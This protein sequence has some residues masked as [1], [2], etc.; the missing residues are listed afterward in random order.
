MGD[1]DPG[2][3]QASRVIRIE[4]HAVSCDQ[5]RSQDP[6][7]IE[8]GHRA[9]LAGPPARLRSA[10]GEQVGERSGSGCEQLRLV[11][12][13]GQMR[14]PGTIREVRVADERV[15]EVRSDGV[16]RV[17]R[18]PDL[19]AC[20]AVVIQGDHPLGQI[21]RCVP[22]SVAG[23]SAECLEV[24]D[25]TK[26]RL[27]QGAGRRRRWDRCRRRSSSRVE[28]SAARRPPPPRG[29]RQCPSAGSSASRDPSQPE[30]PP[31]PTSPPVRL[32]SRWQCASTNPGSRIASPRSRSGRCGQSRDIWSAVPTPRSG[33]ASTAT[34]PSAIGGPAI[35]M[36]W[37]ARRRARGS[38]ERLGVVALSDRRARSARSLPVIESLNSRTPDPR[39]RATSGS[40]LAPKITS[41]MTSTMSSCG[42]P[43]CPK[44]LG[45]SRS[46]DASPT[47]VAWA[48]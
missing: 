45:P 12:R 43:I 29:G 13:F 19:N 28:G 1:A 32:H 44:A 39:L 47:R 22:G 15:P 18:D 10:R 25:A 2:R 17:G 14:G 34:D 40:R 26:A 6:G 5:T 20:A 27:A 21:A 36:T 42:Q 23:V 48:S 30:N 46:G 41:T 11:R 37:A 35:G 38:L 31:A 4:L 7:T 16:R 24:N 33:H 8:S 3:R 9:S